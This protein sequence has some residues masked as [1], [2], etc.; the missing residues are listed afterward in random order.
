M[1]AFTLCSPYVRLSVR[2]PH[3]LLVGNHTE[4][5]SRDNSNFKCHSEVKGQRSNVKSQGD[6]PQKAQSQN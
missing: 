2:L 4:G 6:Q 3:N 1:A 5:W